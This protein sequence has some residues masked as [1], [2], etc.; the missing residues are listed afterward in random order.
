MKTGLKLS[1][2]LMAIGLST[3]LAA[4]KT[5]IAHV[6]L[7]SVDGLHDSDLSHYIAGHP[8]SALAKLSGHGIT[9][10]NAM[11]SFPSLTM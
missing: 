3:G 5:P 6:L 4:A 1:A 2:A 7:I 9:Y 10:S 8:Q 11:T